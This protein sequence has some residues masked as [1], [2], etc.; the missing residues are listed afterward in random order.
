MATVKNKLTLL[1]Q[2]TSPRINSITLPTNVTLPNTQVT[3]LGAL[4]TANTVSA[5]SQ[6]TG[7]GALALLSSVNPA[8]QI[9]AGTL[10]ALVVYAGNITASQITAGTLASGVTYTGSITTTQLAS[11]TAAYDSNQVAFGLGIAWQPNSQ[12]SGVS[13]RAYGST[14]LAGAF[15]QYNTNGFALA[16]AAPPG[17]GAAVVA[18][19]G[20]NSINN[21]RTSTAFLATDTIGGKFTTSSNTNEAQ[22]ATPSY[23]GLFVGPITVIGIGAAISTSGSISGQAI[24]GTTLSL[25]GGVTATTGQFTGAWAC[26]GSTP[27]GKVSVGA[28]LT[29]SATLAEVIAKCNAFQVT[30]VNNGQAQA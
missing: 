5:S 29:G 13:G 28:M 27:Q 14:K 3:G 16:A 6:V 20:W 30:L 19:G 11:G 10:A 8:T 22:L 15:A 26:N 7:L 24:S 2:A 4:A 12:I 21:T 25:T 23:A 9:S 18:Y 17:T 1:L